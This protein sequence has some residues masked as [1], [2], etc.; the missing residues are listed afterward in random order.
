ML[1]RW[2]L[3]DKVDE[4]LIEA[5]KAKKY[6]IE[7]LYS[8][9]LKV[10]YDISFPELATAI[11]RYYENEAVKVAHERVKLLVISHEYSD[12]SPDVF[13]SAFTSKIIVENPDT[14]LYT[15]AGE[16]TTIMWTKALKLVISRRK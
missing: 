12:V 13:I 7:K 8:D 5:L 4:E 16:I 9:V 3:V 11:I 10:E 2:I 15:M 14:S 1:R 6:T